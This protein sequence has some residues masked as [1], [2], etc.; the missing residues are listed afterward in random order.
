VEQVLVYPARP[1]F[2]S[3]IYILR[4][5]SD[6]AGAE[7]VAAA[8]KNLRN[9]VIIDFPPVPDA[10]PNCCHGHN[11]SHKLAPGA[12]QDGFQT[13]TF[14]MPSFSRPSGGYEMVLLDL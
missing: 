5:S 10:M 9:V 12:L 6:T 13:Y 8:L 2:Y 11:S 14:L 3:R 1:A 7:R 4:A